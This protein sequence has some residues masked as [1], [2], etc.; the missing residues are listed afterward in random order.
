MPRETALKVKHSEKEFKLGLQFIAG[1]KKV[2]LYKASQFKA[3][4]TCGLMEN[5]VFYNDMQTNLLS[6]EKVRKFNKELVSVT[7]Q[8]ICYY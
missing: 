8:I 2:S 6:L 1:R 4:T 5:K 7:A 3:L